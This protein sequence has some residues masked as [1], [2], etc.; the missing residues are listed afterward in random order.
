MC[1]ACIDCGL[2][3]HSYG[4]NTAGSTVSCC[5]VGDDEWTIVHICTFSQVHYPFPDNSCPR[6]AVV[7]PSRYAPIHGRLIRSSES[8]VALIHINFI[9]RS[10]ASGS[11]LIQAQLQ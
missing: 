8:L 5:L 11:S 1:D 6:S 3:K 4:T 7:L 9:D 2:A 10:P